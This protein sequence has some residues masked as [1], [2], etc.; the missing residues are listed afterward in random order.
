MDV[1]DHKPIFRA[2]DE[3]AGIIKQEDKKESLNDF[4]LI[5]A[6]IG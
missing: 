1:A 6:H 2:R 3:A 5:L 4:Y